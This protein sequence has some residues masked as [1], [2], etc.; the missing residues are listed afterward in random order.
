MRNRKEIRVA[1]LTATL[2][3]LFTTCIFAHDFFFAHA[4]VEYNEMEDRLECTLTFTTHDLEKQWISLGKTTQPFEKSIADSAFTKE[5]SHFIS[6]HFYVDLSN[7]VKTEFQI[8]G[9][10]S[11]TNGTTNLYM[12]VPLQGAIPHQIHFDLLMDFYPQQQNKL[13][14]IYRESKSSYVFLPD[15]RKQA[16]I[17]SKP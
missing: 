6:E 2:F 17:I 12:S 15:S 13:T 14:F 1:Y 10:E 9:M 3:T 11:M 4:E 16:L 5:L 7:K 8:D